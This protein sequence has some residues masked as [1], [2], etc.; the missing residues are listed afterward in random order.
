[1]HRRKAFVLLTSAAIGTGFAAASPAQAQLRASDGH[2]AWVVEV[3]NRME[4][5]KPG[6]TRKALLTVF[7]TEGGLYTALRRT[8]VSRDCPYFKVTVEFQ[9]VGHPERDVNGRVTS[10]EGDSDII[11]T[12]SAPYLQHTVAD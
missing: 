3:L 9:P 4:T 10:V 8:F 2:L 7:T 1:M 5:I 11:K 6:M 12:I